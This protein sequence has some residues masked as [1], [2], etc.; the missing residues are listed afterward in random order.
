MPLHRAFEEYE[1]SPDIRRIYGDIRVSFDLPFVNTIFKLCAGCPD[2]LKLMWQDLAP[3]ARSCEFQVAARAMHEFVR[4][5]TVAGGWRFSDQAKILAAQK[6]DQSESA[7]MAA[8]VAT[9]ERAVVNMTLFTRLMQRGYS[10]GQRGRI[11]SGKSPA[12]VSRLVTLHV[13]AED[14]AGLRT[15]LIY[16]DIKRT[17]NSK[18]VLSTFRVISP[19][20]GYLGSVWMDTKKVM[21]APGFQRAR[22][23]VAK[24]A[25]ALLVGLPVRDH[26]ALGKNLS[27][28]DWKA[29][30][31][32]VDSFARVAPALALVCAVWQ[33]S[34]PRTA[35]LL[36]A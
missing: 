35:N 31:E 2:Y 10:G 18:Y 29:V 9:L 24:R 32:T 22:D 12:A 19:F 16:S 34:F 7:Q 23:E 30:E 20:P 13:P 5:L 11:T 4:S 36:A 14:D 8:I 25:L 3:V 17:F 26:R 33:R 1:V 6:F 27:P 21:G 28:T 15:W